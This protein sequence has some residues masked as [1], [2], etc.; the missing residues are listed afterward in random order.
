MEEPAHRF[1]TGDHFMLQVLGSC[2]LT[3]RNRSVVLENWP[4]KAASLLRLLA[5]IDE[6]RLARDQAI[7]LLWPEVE[8]EAGLSNL[9]SLLFRLRRGL[10]E[11]GFPSP[12]ALEHGQ[13]ALNPTYAF[14]IDAD[15]FQK[16]V[17]AGEELAVLEEAA[18]MVQGEL[19]PEDRYED[20]AEPVR[21]QLHR[22]AREL[23]LRLARAYEWRAMW[24]AAERI[25]GQL[26]ALD[27]LDEEVAGEQ[28]RLLGAVG[29]RAEAL[30]R[31][32]ELADILRQELGVD[33]AQGLTLLAAELRAGTVAGRAVAAEE[34]L[35]AGGFLGATPVTPLVGKGAELAHCLTIASE[36]A[37]GDGRCVLL[38]GE[39]GI[40]KTRLAQEV[41][42]YLRTRAFVVATGSCYEPQQAVPHYP[43]LDILQTLWVQAPSSVRQRAAQHWPYLGYL[44]PLAG[45]PHLPAGGPGEQDRL[46]RAVQ[47][48]VSALAETIPVALL[49]DDLHWA[50]G[51]TLEL[52]LHLVRHTRDLGVF[53]M[54]TY[55]DVE[56]GRDHPL[57]ALI[58]DLD[59]EG[60]LDRAAMGPLSEG[61][62][63]ALIAATLGECEASEGL[64]TFVYR[65][66]EGNPFFVQ[67]VLRA[68]TERGEL[69]HKDGRWER[70]STDGMEVP[71][72]VRSVIGRRVGRLSEETQYVLHRASI[73]GQTFGFED[74]LHMTGRPEER[75][76]DALHE[77]MQAAF[78]RETQADQFAFD[79]ALT[80][81]TLYQELSTRK[82]RRLH[83]AA[84]EAIEQ[85][86]ERRPDERAPK[87][88]WHFLEG[89]DAKRALPY[90]LV[91]GDAAEAVFAHTDAERHY[92][93]AL[94]LA[95][96][97]DDRPREAEALEKLGVVLWFGAHYDQSRE[98]LE[99]AVAAYQ[100][101]DEPEGEARA[102][103]QIGVALFMNGQSTD[104]IARVRSTI[105]RLEGLSGSAPVRALAYLYWAFAVTLF[106]T[107]EY[108]DILSVSARL[109]ELGQTAND[110]KV[111]SV[112]ARIRGYG[113][114]AVGSP[115]E[116]RRSLE[117]ALPFFTS[118]GDKFQLGQVTG[119]IGRTY[120]HEGDVDRASAYFHQTV[121]LFESIE[122]QAELAWASCYLGDVAFVTGDWAGAR[123][124]YERSA[125]LAST[126]V[127]RYH[128]HALLHLAELSLLEGANE[129]AT[130]AIKQ[131]LAVAEQCSEVPAI[132]KAARLLAELDL[133]A[134][135]AD[136]ALARL[137]PLLDGLGTETP[138]AFP[139]PVLAEV[140]L[141]TGDEDRAYQLVAGRIERFRQQQRRRSLAD[142]LRIQGKVRVQQGR[143]DEARQA[144]EEAAS[145]AH[146]LSFRYAEAEALY[147]SGILQR[148]RAEVQQARA[149]LEEALAIF[150][151]LA[152]R[153]SVERTEQ[154]LHDLG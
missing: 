19:L 46:F 13:V 15:R 38:R 67:H 73:L 16:L 88:A 126:T 99:R 11:Q 32:E 31:Y 149:R 122:D 87:L 136:G 49:L 83:L 69:Y 60:L 75:L 71:E 68:L 152:A 142:W 102:T 25:L 7:E 9:K 129:Q 111:M 53:V 48:F 34:R 26:L 109:A 107:G 35:P 62:V 22:Q 138:H 1:P 64:S 12:I 24:E 143:W 42:V 101:M 4:R 118:T 8:P 140:Y 77:A 47:A 59:R 119:D 117:K 79:H 2:R 115:S 18:T 29:R 45:E 55:R 123:R 39:P 110:A 6:H 23:L 61:D 72:T 144:Y 147:E 145:L 133:A 76:D 58:R 116:A 141:A 63:A 96:R 37:A 146:A 100:A 124:H 10:E 51:G 43:F 82:R 36:V 28:I 130:E 84:G 85:Q 137:Q 44:L 40:G 3:W 95:R 54:G 70:N 150:R 121:E 103:R 93:T 21:E 112:A 113:L 80:Q 89:D 125:A 56:V 114:C 106:P 108:A 98:V 27:P 105:E 151:R 52:L 128:S 50:D 65:R 74:L 131:G 92:R 154:A 139:P 94:E 120:L 97:T 86:P 17:A 132:R 127:L 153:P 91:A 66:T 135:D 57:E 90:A 30:R 134:G 20:W 104:G 14:T 81:E 5:V 148:P 33:P 78:V 41:T